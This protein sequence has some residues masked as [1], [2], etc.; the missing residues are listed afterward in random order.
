VRTTDWYPDY[1]TRLYD[2][3]AAEWTGQHVHEAVAV[4]GRTGQLQG[5]LQHYA[6]R[7]IADHLETIDRYTT[8]A[9][10]QMHESGRRAGTFDLVGHPPLAFPAKLPRQRRLPRRRCRLHHFIDE[11]VLR[12]P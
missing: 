10:R 8:L 2:R 6:Y 12:V 7:S 11:R 1:Q 9:A 5:E 4:R 3:R